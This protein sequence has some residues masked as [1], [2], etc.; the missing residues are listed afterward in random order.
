MPKIV[1]RLK[2][3]N[4]SC[5]AAAISLFHSSEWP[6]YSYFQSVQINEHIDAAIKLETRVKIENP[7]VPQDCPQLDLMQF[8]ASVIR[9]GNDAFDSGQNLQKIEN[10]SCLEVIRCESMPAA[11]GQFMLHR[12][13]ELGP[14]Q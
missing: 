6:P 13:V 2:S 1:Q 10:G 14:G 12:L 11:E 3:D 5:S 7:H 9:I 8:A 4:L